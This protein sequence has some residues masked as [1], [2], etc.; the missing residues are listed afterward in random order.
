MVVG[1]NDLYTGEL[2]DDPVI[3]RYKRIQNATIV[4]MFFSHLGRFIVAK[5][6]FLVTRRICHSLCECMRN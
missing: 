6:D 2:L 3:T 5:F 1:R 4:Y